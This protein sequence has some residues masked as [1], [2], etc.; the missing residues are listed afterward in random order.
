MRVIFLFFWRLFYYNPRLLVDDVRP[1][2]VP[3][4]EEIAGSS[5]R[6]NFFMKIY[7]LSIEIN[8]TYFHGICQI[9]PERIKKY[10]G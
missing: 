5:E 9:N 7:N 3:V 10:A 1:S 6:I 4:E 8:H 2:V